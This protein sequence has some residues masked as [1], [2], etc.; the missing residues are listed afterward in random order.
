MSTQATARL[1]T[2]VLVRLRPHLP[3][4]LNIEVTPHH[5]WT[6]LRRVD[7]AEEDLG[8][9]QRGSMSGISVRSLRPWVPFLPRSLRRRLTAQSAVETVLEIGYQGHAIE[10]VSDR[11]GRFATSFDFEVRAVDRREGVVVSFRPP[12]SS[13]RVELLA[14]PSEL[15]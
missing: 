1:L 13:A 12:A 11:P 2:E 8:S 7:H 6:T 9:A 5:K 15:L 10:E 4:E 3:G 14:I